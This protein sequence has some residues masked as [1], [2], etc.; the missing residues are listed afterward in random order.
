MN[1]SIK[2]ETAD[3]YLKFPEIM[4]EEFEDLIDFI[5]GSNIRYEGATDIFIELQEKANKYDK[6]LS[7]WNQLEEWL[8]EFIKDMENTPVDSLKQQVQKDSF[9]AIVDSILSKIKE[10]EGSDNNENK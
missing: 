7:D 5:E 4:E 3:I 8:K 10:I 9:L 6:L 2:S 1:E